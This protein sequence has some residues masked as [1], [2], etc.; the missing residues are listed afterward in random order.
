[1]S[2]T[3][4]LFLRYTD[5]AGTPIDEHMVTGNWQAHVNGVKASGATI[6]HIAIGDPA[7]TLAAAGVRDDLLSYSEHK[8]DKI[9]AERVHPGWNLAIIFNAL[10]S[11]DSVLYVTH[12]DTPAEH[13][14]KISDE[15]QSGQ[16]S[17]VKIAIRLSD[18]GQDLWSGSSGFDQLH[19][20]LDR[21]ETMMWAEQNPATTLD[22]MELMPA[23]E[24]ADPFG[25]YGVELGY[26][27]KYD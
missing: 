19:T 18:S 24:A 3:T 4:G 12:T 5:K 22:G 14:G 17:I 26:T 15:D 9:S 7:D 1:M 8:D 23:P 10:Q 21:A 2:E 20:K 13:I 27:V 6:T 16:I 25:D 11:D